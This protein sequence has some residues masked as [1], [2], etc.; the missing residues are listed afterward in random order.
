VIYTR[1]AGYN[2]GLWKSTE[3]GLR[4]EGFPRLTCPA[5]VSRINGQ[6]RRYWPRESVG[7]EVVGFCGGGGGWG[8][9]NVPRPHAQNIIASLIGIEQVLSSGGRKQRSRNTKYK[10]QSKVLRINRKMRSILTP[11]FSVLEYSFYRMSVSLPLPKYLPT[12]T[13]SNKLCK[14]K[15]TYRYSKIGHC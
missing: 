1:R 7:D 5:A 4:S 8:W 2:S 12:Y 13:F 14:K 3:D 6:T 11:I 9:K 10:G 15:Y